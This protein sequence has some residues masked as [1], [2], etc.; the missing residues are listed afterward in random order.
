MSGAF[1]AV[2]GYG[3]WGPG[4][5]CTEQA[6]SEGGYEPRTSMAAPHGETV[7]KKTIRQVLGG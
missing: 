7:L 6:F 2:A 1:V 4:Y 5:I 3:D